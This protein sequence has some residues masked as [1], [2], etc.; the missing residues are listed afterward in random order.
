MLRPSTVDWIML[1]ALTVMWGSAFLLT[2]IA[3]EGLPPTLVVAGRLAVACLLLLLLAVAWMRRLPA[4][5]RHWYF[6]VLIAFF[7]NALPFSLISWGQG[8]IDSGLAGIL[9]AVMPL[10]TLGLAHFL[11]PGERMTLLRAIGFLLGFAG[12]VILMGPQALLGLT[13]IDTAFFPMLAI[14]AGAV[15]YAFSVILA[16]LRPQSD[17]FASAAATTLLATLMVMPFG[18]QNIEIAMIS[19]PKAAQLSAVVALGVFS[20]AIAAVVYFLLIA[21]AGP[22]FVSQ[23]SYLIPVWAVVMGII[24]LGEKPEFDH[25]YA[26]ALI[27]GGILMTQLPRNSKQ[28][29]ARSSERT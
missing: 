25:L 17:A 11:I 12:V 21:R 15:S 29:V 6:Y 14:L 3:V 24:F 9:M 28:Q 27:L 22:S 8:Y 20:T 16:R 4:G 18:F 1:L 19:P 7:G 13:H 23:L 10:V 2:K 5:R 26:L